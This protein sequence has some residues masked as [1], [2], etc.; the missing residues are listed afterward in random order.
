MTEPTTFVI[1]HLEYANFKYGMADVT[2]LLAQHDQATQRARGRP[3]RDLEVFKRAAVILS[4]TAWET[5]VED[6]I[7]TIARERIERATS[8]ADVQRTFN[9][10]VDTWHAGLQAANQRVTPSKLQ[11]W[12]GDGWKARLLE[13]LAKSLDK[14]NTPNTENISALSKRFL[15]KDLTLLWRWQGSTPTQAA[16]R[17]DTLIKL[18]GALVHRSGNVLE[19]AAVRRDDVIEA[20]WLL[21]KLVEITATGVGRAPR[22]VSVPTGLV[23][24]VPAAES[25]PTAAPA[26]PAK[27]APLVVAVQ[28]P[29]RTA[30]SY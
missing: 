16:I 14:L 13:N 30:S 23:A 20:M 21:N 17:L 19:P 2:T 10:C 6:I 29:D 5:Y 11:E 1:D 15:E 3:D 8:P 26:G 9:A 27:V 24:P 25:T 12:T 28:Q 18:R 7:T 4:V 22:S